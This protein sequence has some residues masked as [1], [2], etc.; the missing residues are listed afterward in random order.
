MKGR[1]RAV[2][3][4][5]TVLLFISI[6]ILL[7]YQVYFHSVQQILSEH[8]LCGRLC[9]GAGTQPWVTHT[10]PCLEELTSRGGLPR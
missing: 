9:P 8:L 10:D 7:Q 4:A 5:T 6:W 1:W 2:S 3:K